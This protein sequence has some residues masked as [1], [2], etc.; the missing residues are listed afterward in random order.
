MAGRSGGR[1][2]VWFMGLRTRK[3]VALVKESE[4]REQMKHRNFIE[5]S[6]IENGDLIVPMIMVLICLGLAG[7][8]SKCHGQGIEESFANSV[9]MKFVRISPGSFRMG[10]GDSDVRELPAE[11]VR[12]KG[13]FPRGDF[14]EHPSHTVRITQPYYIGVYEVT[15]AQYEQ[16]DPEHRKL[17]GKFGRSV[18]DD[19]AVIYVN[20]N[21]AVAFCEWLSKREKRPYRLPTEAE[22]EYACRAGTRDNYCTGELLPEQV[23]K[24]PRGTITEADGSSR[25]ILALTVGAT[26]ANGWGVYDMHGN[27]EEWC[28]DWYGPYEAGEQVDP[29]GRVDGDFKVTRGG[30]YA[31]HPYYMRSSNRAGTIPEDKLSATGFRVVVAELPK[32]TALAKAAPPLNQR[33]VNQEIPADLGKGPDRDKAYFD[34]P[35]VYVKIPDGSTGP[36]FWRHNHNS[37]IVEFPNGDLLALWFSCMIE[38]SFEAS[39]AGSRLRYG[40]TE[41]EPASVFWNAPSRDEH[42]HSLWNDGNGTVYHFNTVGTHSNP[43]TPGMIV[44]TSGDSGATWSKAR[45]IYGEPALWHSRGLLKTIFRARGGEIIFPFDGFGGAYLMVSRDNGQSWKD[46]GGRIRGIHAVVVQLGDGRLMAL[47]RRGAIDGKMPVNISSDMGKTWTYSA[48]AFQPLNLGQKPAMLRLSEGPLFFASFCRDMAITD[49]SGQK[50]LISGLFGAVSYDDG[51]TWPHRRLI[52]DDGPGRWIETMDGHPV[53]MDA[54]ESEYVGYMSACQPANGVIHLLTSRQHYSFNLKWLTSPPAAVAERYEP[55]AVALPVKQDLSNIYRAEKPPHKDG[56]GWELSIRDVSA[57]EA[58]V[59]TGGG[60]LKI[61]TGKGRLW[62]RNDG[63][64]GKLDASRGFTAEIRARIHKCLA[65]TGGVELEL[66]DGF[67]S[68]YA[69]TVTDTGAYWYEGLMKGSGLLRFSEYAPIAEGLDNT[70]GMHTWRIAV[71]ED[72]VAQIYRDGRLLGTRRYEYR[73]P[74]DAYICFGAGTGTEATVDYVG[75]DLAGPSGPDAGKD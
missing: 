40:K 59:V 14:D 47:S 26:G 4:G 70:D 74:R 68:R 54:Y 7:A 13:L 42:G 10:F 30:S 49:A 16:F 22:W 45:P 33:N 62:W 32:S 18:D 38:E 67:G 44:R 1:K 8:A 41:W 15:N 57:D 37:S 6:A 69:L 28:H 52:S 65:N 3:E 29:V 61:Q 19:E 50:R 56:I 48:S 43:H 27:V 9:G 11:M 58:A 5:A 75:Y 21:E 64:F 12:D 23:V 72:R 73:T 36:L 51:K 53:R 63:L 35:R 46:P 20:W 71:R 24:R 66:Y 31:V 39:V 55:Q 34:G 2:P 17:R 25:E 60:L